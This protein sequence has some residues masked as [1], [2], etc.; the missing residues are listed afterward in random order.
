MD[1]RLDQHNQKCT[2][3]SP[4]T[5][6]LE[7]EAAQNTLDGLNVEELIWNHSAAAAAAVAQQQQRNNESIEHQEQKDEEGDVIGWPR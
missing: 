7:H 5:L 2:S 1:C 6:T 3:Q 4:R